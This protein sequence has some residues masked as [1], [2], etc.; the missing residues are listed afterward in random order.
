VVNLNIMKKGTLPKNVDQYISGFDEPVQQKLQQIRQTILAEA[1]QA[2]EV[3]SYGM[4]AYIHQGVLVYFA[5]YKNHIGFYATPTGHAAFRKELS[6]Y[7]EGKGS[8]QFP[9]DEPLPLKLIARIV[10][11]RVKENLEKEKLKLKARS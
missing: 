7:K 10:K 11:Y 1:P 9:M 6:A 3:I 2:E 8:V 4:P 5:G